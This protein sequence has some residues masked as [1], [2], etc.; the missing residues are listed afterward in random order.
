[1]PS[2]V[3]GEAKIVYELYRPR[4]VRSSVTVDGRGDKGSRKLEISDSRPAFVQNVT[5]LLCL[6]SPYVLE[7]A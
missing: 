2:G 7:P 1:M 5:Y 6:I 4:G 3:H